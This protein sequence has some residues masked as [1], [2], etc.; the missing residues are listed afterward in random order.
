ME[1]N[2]KTFRY[3][4]TFKNLG[5]FYLMFL[6]SCVAAGLFMGQREFMFSFL[7]IMLGLGVILLIPY[8]SSSVTTSDLKI[9]TRTLFGSKSLMWSEIGR[10]SSRGA[11]LRLHSRKADVV[12]TVHP[13]LDGSAEIFNLIFSK[14][15]DLFDLY[16]NDPF[17]CSTTTTIGTLVMGLLFVIL[18]LFLYFYK[19]YFFVPGVL[20]LLFCIQSVTYLYI[21][22]R[23]ITLENSRLIVNYVNKSISYSAGDIAAIQMGV[24]PQKQFVDVFM[25]LKDKRVMKMPRFKQALF[26]VY[27]V[28]KQWHEKAGSSQ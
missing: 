3:T 1:T 8:L 20:G 24:T 11:S 7:P 14:R 21:N 17:S 9:S 28:L 25:V 12:L 5:V 26:I 16:K 4:Y 6:F 18:A 10:V 2:E 19:N 22:P 15:A 23:N 27:P 13:R